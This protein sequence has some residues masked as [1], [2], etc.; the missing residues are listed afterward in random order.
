M[1]TIKGWRSEHRGM[2]K[3]SPTEPVTIIRNVFKKLFVPNV[4]NY[5]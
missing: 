4:D 1:F 3:T 5:S 2:G